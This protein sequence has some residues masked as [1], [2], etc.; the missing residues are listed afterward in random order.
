[1]RLAI[2]SVLLAAAMLVLPAVFEERGATAP[3]T[4]AAGPSDSRGATPEPTARN[5][6]QGDAVDAY[7]V[8]PGDTLRLIAVRVYGDESRWVRIYE[9]NRDLLAS[10]DDLVAGLELVIP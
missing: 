2:M 5:Q 10:P 4:P 1:L 7:I 9:A 3:S 6:R 8:K